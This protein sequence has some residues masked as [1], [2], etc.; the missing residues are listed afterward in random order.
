MVHSSLLVLTHLSCTL[1]LTTVLVA[2]IAS[3]QSFAT[4]LKLVKSSPVDSLT[5]V[6][7]QPALRSR[8]PAQ[9]CSTTLPI[10]HL[11]TL[12]A[13]VNL[14]EL[15]LARLVNTESSPGTLGLLGSV[16]STYIYFLLLTTDNFYNP[17]AAIVSFKNLVAATARF[18]HVPF[19]KT[20]SFQNA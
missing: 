1:F 9:S 13:L 18:L 19:L 10:V 8:A 6:L 15:S 5:P 3:P 16:Y 17:V 7:V 2:A 4:A 20:V 14:V 12:Q 11:P